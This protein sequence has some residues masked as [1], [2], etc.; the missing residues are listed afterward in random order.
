VWRQ[1]HPPDGPEEAAVFCVFILT[2]LLDDRIVADVTV[3]DP[4]TEKRI[5]RGDNLTYGGFICGSLIFTQYKQFAE[6]TIQLLQSVFFTGKFTID[7]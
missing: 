6:L 5:V 3:R 7:S 1:S 2:A 4:R